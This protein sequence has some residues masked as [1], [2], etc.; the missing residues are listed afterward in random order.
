[1]QVISRPELPLYRL[2]LLRLMYAVLA[3]LQGYQTW[4]AILRHT[5]PWEFWDGVGHSFLGAL[6]LLSLLGIRYPVRMIPLLIFEFTWKLVWTLAIYLPQYLRH[7]LDHDTANN[8]FAISLG[9][10]IVP[11]LLPWGYIWRNYVSA[12][13]DRWR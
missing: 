4:S 11:L 2:Y 9:V 6:T 3:F 7:Q 12:S 5:G 8:L 13:A 1:M 10:V